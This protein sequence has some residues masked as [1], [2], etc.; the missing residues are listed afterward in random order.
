MRLSYVLGGTS[1]LGY[2]LYVLNIVGV[3]F[4]AKHWER[5]HDWLW[6]GLAAMLT[7]LS[8][9]AIVFVNMHHWMTP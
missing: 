8:W 6:P 1:Y 4:C 5:S 9:L 7:V 2:A 3:Y